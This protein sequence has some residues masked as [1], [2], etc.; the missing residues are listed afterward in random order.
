[1]S[2]NI[3]RVKTGIKGLDKL[4]NGG[5]PKNSS[6]LL[7]GPTGSGKTT[8]GLEFLYHGAK[9][10]NEK[11]IFISFE[12]TPEELLKNF[13]F[14]N[15]LKN[16]VAEGKIR[17][18][19]YDPYQYEDIIDLIRMNVREIDAKRVVIDSITSLNLYIEDVKDIR[20]LISD[21]DSQLK[22]LDCT[23]IYTGEIRSD[24][25]SRISSY[26]VEEFI[27]DAVIVLFIKTEK[28][29]LKNYLLIRK[30]RG[31]DHDRKIHLFK[32]GKEGIEIIP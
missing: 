14:H 19:K 20:K 32:F 15:D 17:L 4:L 3:E 2:A 26:G 11:G 23:T 27:S 22:K 30:V 8:F 1:M 28:S 31:S 12:E 25:P 24:T 16:L 7:S 18:L 13:P 6:L 5:L 21:L 29:E 9:E 10:F